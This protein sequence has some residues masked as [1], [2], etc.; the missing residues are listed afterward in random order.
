[1]ATE[2]IYGV[3]WTPEDP[4]RRVPGHLTWDPPNSPS[5]EV[6]DP[7][8][9]FDGF[10]GHETIP[11]ILGDV[12]RFGWMTLLNCRYA[13]MQFGL[14][15]TRTFHVGQAISRLRIATA[16]EQFC[17]RVEMEIP[18]LAIL[19]GP[20]PIE[21]KSPLSSRSREA[22]LTLDRRAHVWKEDDV[23]VKAWYCWRNTPSDLG[24]DL[25]MSPQIYLSTPRSRPFEYWMEEW[26]VPL[27]VLFSVAT[28]SHFRPRSIRLW[29]KKGISR[30]ERSSD[31][32]E[33]W[34]AGVDPDP[35]PDSVPKADRDAL[36]PLVSIEQLRDVSI[37]RVLSRTRQFA[38]EYEVFWSLLASVLRDTGRP[39]RNRYLDVIAALEAFDSRLHG[40]GPIEISQY[41]RQRKHA[42][43]AV[44]D[45]DTRKFL[46][47]WVR[48]RSEYSLHERLRRAA[49][50]VHVELKTDAQTMAEVRNDIAH[51]NAHP[52]PYLLHDCH[53]QAVEMARRLALA[54]M[55]L[56]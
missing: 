24:V 47:R 2:S 21:L 13:G 34:T 7:P 1:M 29:T 40:I 5:L 23:E 53:A 18:A 49:A 26:L 30:Y 50:S 51:G 37:H 15:S 55:G 56:G 12:A 28:A 25:R 33:L 36:H 11:L 35:A 20:H 19:L 41:K 31:D 27:S 38:E 54:E 9:S 6:L 46:K 17:R 52:D 44:M 22:R 10:G 32:L 3:W 42:L 43:D 39:L 8:R 14:T 48:G 45:R 16:S 4:D